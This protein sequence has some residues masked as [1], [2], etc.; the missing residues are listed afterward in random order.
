MRNSETILQLKSP[1]K[2]Y[3]LPVASSLPTKTLKR[4]KKSTRV[5]GGHD[6]SKAANAFLMVMLHETICNDDFFKKKKLQPGRCVA[7]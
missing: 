6:K 1:T 5:L 2:N 3:S 4:L 7:I